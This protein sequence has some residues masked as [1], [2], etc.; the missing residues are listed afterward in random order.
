MQI[1]AGSLLGTFGPQSQS[2][3]ER[4]ATD[5]LVHFVSTD[6]HG[7]K[8]RRP[9]LAAAHRRMAELVGPVLAD[10]CCRRESGG[11]GRGAAG[12]CRPVRRQSDPQRL[13][14]MEEGRLMNVAEPVPRRWDSAP[15]GATRGRAGRI[16][17][18]LALLL[19][20]A[21]VDTGR[22]RPPAAGLGRRAAERAVHLPGRLSARRIRRAVRRIGPIARRSDAVARR[23]A[24]SRAGRAVL[25]SNRARLSHLS[26]GPSAAS[27]LSPGAVREG[28]RSGQ[29]LCL[30]E[31][32]VAGRRA[33]RGDAR[34]AA[35]RVADGAAVARRRAGRIFR[36][37]GRQAEPTTIL[38]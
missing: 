27:S 33:A 2:V 38:T 4:L 9:Q 26:A 24:G 19:A 17:S 25:V 29:G 22:R 34:T 1:T 16:A 37:A 18:V 7:L 13:V 28:A 23:R 20:T 14:R 35:R 21:A 10:Q 8:T 3:A 36:G 11:G 5:G 30:Q 12:R 31:Q 15:E 32:G 6:A